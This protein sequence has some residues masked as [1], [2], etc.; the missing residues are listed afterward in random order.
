MLTILEYATPEDIRKVC[1]NPKANACTWH[2]KAGRAVIAVVAPRSWCDWTQLKTWGHE[3]V[4]VWGKAHTKAFKQYI[5]AQPRWP[6]R[7]E[8]CHM[9]PYR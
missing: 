8:N 9:V 3:L 4:H 1:D 5:D 7:G 2:W 6:M